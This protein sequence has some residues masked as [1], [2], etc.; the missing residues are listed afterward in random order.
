MTP[1]L[2]EEGANDLSQAQQNFSEDNLQQ[3]NAQT[4]QQDSEQNQQDFQSSQQNII[5]QI[6]TTATV[7]AAPT[8]TPAPT[9][10]PIPAPTPA[11]TPAPSPAP[12]ASAAPAIALRQECFT[13]IC[14]QTISGRQLVYSRALEIIQDEEYLDDVD[15]DEIKRQRIKRQISILDKA[16]KQFLDSIEMILL[17]EERNHH[18]KK[19]KRQKRD[20]EFTTALINA[21]PVFGNN[22]FTT[23]GFAGGIT[24]RAELDAELATF[25]ATE[26]SQFCVYVNTF[27]LT[28]VSNHVCHTVGE[29]AG[30]LRVFP[31]VDG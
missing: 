28:D 12:T 17:R 19:I 24:T 22:L 4:I 18:L 30:G 3:E 11:P 27:G 9:P 6:D 1:F 8:P 14:D 5:E 16:E 7:A 21:Y 2:K 10:A 25:S 23:Y 26:K 20:L 15:F 29:Y 31:N 13:R